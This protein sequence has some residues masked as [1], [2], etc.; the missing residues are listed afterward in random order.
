MATSKNRA[1]ET[2]TPNPSTFVPKIIKVVTVP[3]LKLRAGMTVHVKIEAPMEK[4]KVQ[5]NEPDKEPA[6]LLRVTNLETGELCQIIVGAALH[7]IF[8]DEYPEA[9]YVGRGFQIVIGEQKDSKAGGGKRYNQYT[10]NEIEV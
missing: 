3:L 8:D 1:S 2:A 4:G 7:G 10:V 6:T 9:S 5:K